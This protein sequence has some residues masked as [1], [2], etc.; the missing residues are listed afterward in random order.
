MTVYVLT[1]FRQQ[2]HGLSIEIMGV[3]KTK[4]KASKD[5]TIL[6]K[7]IPEIRSCQIDELEVQG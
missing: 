3:Y 2:K 1:T 7:T 6:L 4:E 5:G